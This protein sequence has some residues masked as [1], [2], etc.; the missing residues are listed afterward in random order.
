MKNLLNKQEENTEAQPENKKSNE[1]IA[2]EVIKG[3]W[4]NGQERKDRLA[5][6][7][8]DASII[9]KIVNEK[10]SGN[11][12]SNKKSNE[13]IADEIIKGLWGNG[14]ERKDKLTSAG[15]DA[16]TIQKIVNEKLK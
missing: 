16:S 11:T 10:L 3:L 6:A 9:Q 7:G 8:Y 5:S 14:Q 1:E 4:G 12:S 15:Y 2:D 13:E